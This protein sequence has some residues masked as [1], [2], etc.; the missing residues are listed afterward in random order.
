[1]MIILTPNETTQAILDYLFIE[2]RLPVDF[3][4]KNP[5]AKIRLFS[6][7]DIAESGDTLVGVGIQITGLGNE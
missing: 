6:E 7:S 5:N 4:E 3:I 2:N 1:M